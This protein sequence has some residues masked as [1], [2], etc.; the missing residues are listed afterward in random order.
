[1]IFM[2]HTE[3]GS[4]GLNSCRFNRTLK[5]RGKLPQKQTL[6]KLSNAIVDTQ[7]LNGKVLFALRNIHTLTSRQA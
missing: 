6:D 1:M 2:I 4:I 5:W 3:L 7:D